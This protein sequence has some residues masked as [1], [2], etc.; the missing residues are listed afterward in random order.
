MQS[1]LTTMQPPC[2]QIQR[3]TFLS[4]LGYGATGMALSMLLN[5]EGS[6]QAASTS[7]R[8]MQANAAVPSLSLCE[9]YRSQLAWTKAMTVCET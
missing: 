8:W 9:I 2:G 1:D 7:L 6:A 4:D 5:R 3:R